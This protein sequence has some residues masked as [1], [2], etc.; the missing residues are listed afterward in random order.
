MTARLLSAD[1]EKSCQLINRTLASHREVIV[2]LSSR[3]LPPRRLPKAAVDREQLQRQATLVRLL[4]ITEA[5]CT[6]RLLAELDGVVNPAGH[7]A[8]TKIWTKAFDAATGTWNGQRDAFKDWLGVDRGR[9]TQVIELTWARNAVAHGYGEL[10][11]RQ[12]RERGVLEAK[13]AAHD[14]VLNGDLIVL[15]ENSISK[16]ADTCRTFIKKVDEDLIAPTS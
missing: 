13:L 3:P 8:V 4:S 2:A 10:T 14:I 12:R 11:Q 9:W 1:A 15:S 6:E 5:F 16:A 7:A